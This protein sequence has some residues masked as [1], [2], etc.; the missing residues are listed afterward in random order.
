MPPA[1]DGK[2]RTLKKQ[3]VVPSDPLSSLLSN[4]HARPE[5]STQSNRTLSPLL[6]VTGFGRPRFDA[7]KSACK[8]DC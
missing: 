4:R 7:P 6:H 1:E 2:G 5:R 8:S 3:K